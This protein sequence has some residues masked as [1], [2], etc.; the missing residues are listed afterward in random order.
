MKQHS[1]TT[2]QLSLVFWFGLVIGGCGFTPKAAPQPGAAAGAGGG[3]INLSTG[4]QGPA[5]GNQVTDLHISPAMAALVVTSGGPAP[6]QQYSVTATVNGASRDVTAMAS[7]T[8]TP[9][10]IVTI[11]GAGLATASG[12]AGGHVTVT[13]TFGG[14]SAQAA[15][16]VSTSFVGADPGPAGQGVPSGADA[17]FSGAPVDPSRAP[18]L[19]YPNDG[20][21]F[22]P[23]VS[24]IEIHFSPG[25]NNTL[26][27]VHLAGSLST[28]TTF[29]RCST[30][31]GVNGCV[32]LPAPSLWAAVASANAGQG[33]VTL[34]VSGTDDS[35]TS[36]GTSSPVTMRFAQDDIQGALYYWTT[37]GQSA[38]VRWD[39]T[40]GS[41]ATTYL[42]P[43]NTDGKTCVGCHALSPAGDKLVASAGGEGD[44][45]LLLWSVT[46]NAALQ[47]FPL[48]QKSQFES[49]NADGSRFVGIY[50]DGL[51]GNAGPVDLMIFDGSTGTMTSTVPLGGLR[52]DH[53]DW[54]KNTTGPERIVFTSA[55]PKAPTPDQQ[56]ATGAIAYV[57]SSN[58]TWSAPQTLVPAQLGKNHYYPAISP[59]GT[60][61]VYDESTCTNGTAAPGQKP[62]T[63]CNGD[64]D[65]TATM[66]L[67]SF[68]GG[69]PVRLTRANSP[70]VAD[71]ATTALTNSFPRWAPFVERLD[72]MHQL[73]WLTFSSTRQ[74]G[75]RSPPPS[76]AP[77]EAVASTL[78]WMVGINLNPDGSD[79]SYSAFCLP[80]QDVTT[81]NHIAQWA[82]YFIKGPG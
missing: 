36:V 5:A 9:T 7:Y 58:G 59:D 57:Q 50:G 30:P 19:V 25:K 28:V 72:E 76:T 66:F 22:P 26:F 29:I 32:Y 64:V 8:A 68:T 41:S 13:A 37:S 51:P 54:S 14:V 69:A 52:A 44:G 43:A 33:P 20:V 4:G 1:P 42:T 39:F 15:L 24:G 56:P 62:D 70:G 60:L 80:F 75:L 74:Y 46:A 61:V 12:M 18:R 21:L 82:K 11:D 31:K 48:T 17:V 49:W 16:N 77:T 47:P 6:T 2:V 65:P 73:I 67:T 78:I 23:N 71:G 38:I 63:S 53:P 55:D 27:A 3:T 40:A 79:P 45:R 81:S 10:G 34:T 35:G